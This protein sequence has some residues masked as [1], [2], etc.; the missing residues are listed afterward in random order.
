MTII[1]KKSLNFINNV[2]IVYKALY[3]MDTFCNN[4]KITCDIFIIVLNQNKKCVQDFI[5]NSKYFILC[6]ITYVLKFV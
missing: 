4:I 5:I 1:V 6:F 2:K 3:F